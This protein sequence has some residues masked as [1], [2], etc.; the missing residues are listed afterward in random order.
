MKPSLLLRPTLL[1]LMLA[2]AGQSHADEP[3]FFLG[4][5]AG[6]VNYGFDSELCSTQL[7]ASC[8]I[9]NQDRGLKLFA[10]AYITPTLMVEASLYDFG[11]LK[12]TV[13]ARGVTLTEEQTAFAAALGGILPLGEHFALTAKAGLFSTVLESTASGPGGTITISDD[14][15]NLM[16]GGGVRLNASANVGLRVEYEFFNAAGDSETDISMATASVVVAF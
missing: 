6:N 2:S 11:T 3:R 15:R 9:D 10:G 4:L 12:G 16:L 8:E 5:G 13:P 7:G 1:A 14:A